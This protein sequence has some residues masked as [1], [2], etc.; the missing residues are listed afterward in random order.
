MSQKKHY[1]ERKDI[2]WLATL[3]GTAVGAGILYLPVSAAK[4]GILPL[5][6][7][8]LI[9]LPAIWLAH[10]NL[11]RF[12]LTAQ[13][14]DDDITS[15]VIKKFGNAAGGFLIIAYFISIFP[16]ALLY[17]IGLT[18][19]INNTIVNIL[20]LSAPPRAV[21]SFV[22][23][24]IL[25]FI[26]YKGEKWVLASAELL[27]I[28]LS[29]TLL[30]C[31]F[32]LIP[33]WT[34]SVNTTFDW[35]TFI[36]ASL[37]ITPLL[38]FSFNHSPACSAFAQS[39]RKQHPSLDICNKKTSRILGI[40]TLLLS[41]VII[42][43]VF[44]CMMAMTPSDVENAVQNNIPAL[45]AISKSGYISWMPY[46]IMGITIFAITSS[47]FGV[48]IGSLEGAT[49]ML[50]YTMKNIFKKNNFVITR[51]KIKYT[52]LLLLLTCW[53]TASINISVISI[54]QTVVAPVLAIL[55]FI[56]PIYATYRL[57]ELKHYRSPIADGFTFLVG[58]VVILG[59]IISFIY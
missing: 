10:R 9:S 39:Y 5:I 43:F 35:G 17:C 2:G 50:N 31:A 25:A 45:I 30:F 23:L 47:F 19:V 3:F 7:V 57:E 40:N 44:S 53:V 20:D 42:P 55:L 8:T 21:T 4:A 51:T 16:I 41:I 46:V 49:G 59:F 13:H 37:T 15:T 34:P 27:V 38:V 58:L 33:A 29:I 18:N 32:Y 22:I 36:K 56:V 54:I 12:C 14:Q 52:N 24:A 28:P 11:T 26:I 48:Y 1:L 6:A